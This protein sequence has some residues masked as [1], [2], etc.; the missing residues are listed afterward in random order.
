[1]TLVSVI[2]AILV[3]AYVIFLRPDEA[4]RLRFGYVSRADSLIEQGDYEAALAQ[5]REALDIAPDDPEI[6]LMIGMMSEAL[7]R[8]EDAAEYYARAEALF[9]SRTTFLAAKSQRY[10]VMRQY[11][12]AEQAALEAIELDDQYAWTYC[13]LGGAYEGQGRIGE[14]ISALQTCSDLA[15]EQGQDELYVIAA[16]RMAMLMQMPLG[17]NEAEPQDEQ[18]SE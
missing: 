7:G 2:L 13:N 10:S 6:N 4:T 12:E 3:V 18:R 8:S 11:E 9:E 5:Y 17:A 16:S 1:M 14:A 15:R